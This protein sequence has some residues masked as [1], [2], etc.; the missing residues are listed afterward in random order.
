MLTSVLGRKKSFLLIPIW[1]RLKIVST[2]A[3]EIVPWCNW[4]HVCFWYRRVQVRALVGQHNNFTKTLTYNELGFF[5][6]CNC[7]KILFTVLSHLFLKLHK[8][9]RFDQNQSLCS[10]ITVFQKRL[11]FKLSISN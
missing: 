5:L 11:F 6:F 10:S 7:Y 2:F 1:Y 4:Q 9:V 3:T 8:I